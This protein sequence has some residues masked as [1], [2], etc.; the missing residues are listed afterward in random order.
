MGLLD[1]LFGR[2]TKAPEQA[3]PAARKV[4][5]R[6]YHGSRA[7]YDGATQGKRAA[8]W[9]RTQRDAN[10]EL[11]PAV[12]AALRGIARDLVRN[13]PF[14]ACGV[15]KVAENIVGAGITF[16][17]YRDGKVDDRLNAIA[18]KHFDTTSCDASGRHD[19]YGLQLQAAR[20]IVESGAV[21][22]RRRW[23]RGRDGFPLP[24][25]LQLL[26]PDYIDPSKNGP[27][28]AAPGA[29]SGFNISGIQFS[30]IGRREGYW[31]YNGHPGGNQT[32]RLGSTFI[33]ASEVAHI[34]RAD[35]PEQEHGAT[36]LAPVVLR[37]RDFADY[38]DGQLTRQ[39]I[40]SAFVG[41][42]KGD[43]DA[44][45]IPG[46]VSEGE[47]PEV[48]GQDVIDRE[49][50]DYVEPGT[51]QYLRNGE[52]I[53]FS[54][55]PGVD[56]YAEYSK[57]SLRAVSVG[58]GV[59]YEVLTGDLSNVS[60]I[61]GRLGRLEFR[62]A[63]STWQWLMFIPQFCGS[64]ERWFLDAL[65]ATGENVSDVEMRWTPPPTEMLDPASEVPAIRDAIR[66]GLSTISAAARERGEDPDKFMA[67]WAA[68]AAKLDAL[69]L[70]FDSDPR[71]VTAV[72]NPVTPA[73][74]QARTERD[75]RGSA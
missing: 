57:V 74:A 37:M 66:A 46:I 21:I 69:G 61:S 9:R 43:D 24:F 67:E 27:M 28:S 53:T 41:V 31:L 51:Y 55:P 26:E 30:P 5:R 19:L 38:E 44:A 71:K 4:I 12:M 75:K 60:F 42:V 13:N 65:E 35:R 14:A 56:G 64:V 52:E 33:A 20:S 3:K 32:G 36:W 1:R 7:E 62:R 50:L 73:T 16:Q 72:G 58:L 15:A 25:Q 2:S 54:S 39:K 45:T 23:R 59:P 34:F 48:P 8:G 40:A 49:P 17:V 11:T 63:V 68:D 22:M 29:V 18:R 10:G 70:T 47:D 6:G